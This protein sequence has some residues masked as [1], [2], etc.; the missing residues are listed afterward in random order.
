MGHGEERDPLG[1]LCALL[2]TL[3][4]GAWTYLSCPS[5]RGVF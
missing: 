1:C 4:R 5:C 3:P 2:L